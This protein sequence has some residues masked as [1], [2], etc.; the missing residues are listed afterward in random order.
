MWQ[1]IKDLVSGTA[2]FFRFSEKKQDLANTP[3]MQENARARQDQITRDAAIKALADCDLAEIR[4]Q[5]AEK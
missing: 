1:F 3:E 4:R 2:A 5:A